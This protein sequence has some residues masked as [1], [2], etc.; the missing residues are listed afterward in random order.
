MPPTSIRAV[1]VAALLLLPVLP[2]AAADDG[3]EADA[4]DVAPEPTRADVRAAYRTRVAAV[5]AQGVAV[6]GADDAATV[7][8]VLED[9]QKLSCEPLDRPDVEFD[10]RVEARTRIADGEPTTRLVNIWLIREGDGWIIR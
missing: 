8:L 7:R 4:K 6:L 2:A 5:N 1:L 9:V 10:C 3:A